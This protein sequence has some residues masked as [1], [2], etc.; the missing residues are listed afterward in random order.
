MNYEQ[1]LEKLA[2]AGQEH[3]LGYY[4]T[5]TTEQKETLLAE[6]E[7]TDFKVLSSLK[8]RKDGDDRGVITPLAAMQLSQIREKEKEFR[9]KGL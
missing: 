8:D 7:A 1:A 9:A 6:I 2:G 5:L 4:D 3:V